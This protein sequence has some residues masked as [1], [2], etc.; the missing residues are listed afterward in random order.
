MSESY[1]MPSAGWEKSGSQPAAKGLLCSQ[2]P[3][4]A[5]TSPYFI[6][7]VSFFCCS[8]QFAVNSLRASMSFSHLFLSSPWDLGVQSMYS[9][10]LW[11]LFGRLKIR[12]WWL[13]LGS[14][15]C[16]QLLSDVLCVRMEASEKASSG[17]RC[18]NCI[19]KE[20]K[21]EARERTAEMVVCIVL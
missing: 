1:S 10:N 13:R 4:A 17:R 3:R 12:K 16:R 14:W 6:V 8:S 21:A 20:E 19:L 7:M 15:S 5:R 18:L 9:K 2:R 11:W